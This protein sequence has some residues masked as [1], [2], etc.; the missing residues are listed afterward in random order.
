MPFHCCNVNFVKGANAGCLLIGWWVLR[1][2]ASDSIIV[3][4]D[5]MLFN[6]LMSLWISIYCFL[7]A[8]FKAMF[9]N[10]CVCVSVICIIYCLLHFQSLQTVLFAYA[11][12]NRLK[13]CTICM[14]INMCYLMS[15]GIKI[16]LPIFHNSLV[17][18]F[19]YIF[20]KIVLIFRCINSLCDSEADNVLH[21]FCSG[22]QRIRNWSFSYMLGEFSSVGLRYCC[23]DYWL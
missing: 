21:I 22:K 20:I 7:V 6:N 2:S 4:N 8:A 3:I 11:N 17:I 5:V 10:M 19:N 16:K 12:L 1:R 15:F 14:Q 13:R 9:L 23:R 18:F